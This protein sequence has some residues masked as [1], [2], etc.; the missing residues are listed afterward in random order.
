MVELWAVNMGMGV[1]QRKL[2]RRLR[3]PGAASARALGLSEDRTRLAAALPPATPL[4]SLR[5]RPDATSLTAE[6][7]EF[8]R[9]A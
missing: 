3:R 2:R 9:H 4:P 5:A 1:G 8:S 7:D 6:R